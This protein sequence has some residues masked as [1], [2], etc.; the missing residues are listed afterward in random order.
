MS[1]FVRCPKCNQPQ[2]KIGGHDRLYFCD[3]CRMQFDDEPIERD[4]CDRDPAWRLER[5]ERRR[6]RRGKR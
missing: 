5:E 2:P 1:E 4:F 3:H 6:N